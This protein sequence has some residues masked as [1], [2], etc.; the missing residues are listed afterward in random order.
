MYVA[1]I[2]QQANDFLA[3]TW[4]R[5][6]EVSLKDEETLLLK[7]VVKNGFPPTKGDIPAPLRKYSDVRDFLNV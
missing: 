5:V 3:V 6:K 1:S 4:D 7:D 2:K